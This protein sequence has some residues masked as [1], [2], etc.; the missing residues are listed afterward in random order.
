[1]ISTSLAAAGSCVRKRPAYFKKSNFSLFLN[2]KRLVG[3]G[4]TQRKFRI[5]PW[6]QHEEVCDLSYPK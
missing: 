2:G 3:Q 4:H 5:K 1:M 6:E